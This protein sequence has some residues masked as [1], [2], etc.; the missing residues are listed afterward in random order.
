MKKTGYLAS[1]PLVLSLAACALPSAAPT[2]TQHD[3]GGIF[4]SGGARSPI[5]LRNVTVGAQPVVATFDMQ[6]REAS[7]PTRRGKYAFNRWAAAP[8][9]MVEAALVRQLAPDGSG[10]CRLQVSLAE[11]I[12][13]IDA[14]G[15]SR[16]VLAA[17][18]SVLRDP[19]TGV[20]AAAMR[21]G[22]DISVPMQE[23]SPAAGA[24]ALREAVIKL[25][26]NSASWLA[27]EPS[28][29]CAA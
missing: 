16:A 1:F 6:Y 14:N 7:Q 13:E 19:Q 24:M 21:Q 11:F 28:R 20:P 10:R 17:D 18:A 3:L 9:A 29:F 2:V 4:P 26:E 27:G 23:T 25:A 5:P 15:K 8:A 12:I 22:F